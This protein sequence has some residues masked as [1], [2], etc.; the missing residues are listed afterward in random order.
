MSAMTNSAHIEVD[1]AKLQPGDLE[2][3]D[4]FEFRAV[5]NADLRSR[6]SNRN[7]RQNV[8]DWVAAELRGKLAFRRLAALRA[9]RESADG[10]IIQRTNQFLVRSVHLTDVQRS[11]DEAELRDSL[12]GTQRFRSAV[13]VAL[14]EAERLVEEDRSERLERAI[15]AHRA[16][17]RPCGP[18]S[19]EPSQHEPFERPTR[20]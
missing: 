12:L 16:A 1:L 10:Q 14:P 3:L 19:T 11:A 2:G 5:V 13:L 8:P 17:T 7:V 20:T 9:M 15:R 4:E 6:A 18:R